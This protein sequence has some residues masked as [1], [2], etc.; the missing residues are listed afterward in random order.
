MFSGRKP[1]AGFNNQS[2]RPIPGEFADERP[3]ALSLNWQN[4][5]IFCSPVVAARHIDGTALLL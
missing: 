3:G 1:P 5:W 2:F 4:L